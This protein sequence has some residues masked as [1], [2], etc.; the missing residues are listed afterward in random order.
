VS[1]HDPDRQVV[2]RDVDLHGLEGAAGGE[3]RHRV[4]ERYEAAR[5]QAGGHTHQVLLGDADVHVPIRRGGE[6]G[7]GEQSGIG[8][9]AHQAR[10][11]RQHGEQFVPVRLAG[12]RNLDRRLSHVRLPVLG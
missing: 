7:T 1:R 4:H 6:V 12:G 3:R 10:I 8:V 9:Q 11:V 2:V 5:G